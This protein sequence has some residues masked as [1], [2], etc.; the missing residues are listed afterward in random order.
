M[1]FNWILIKLTLTGL[2][3][4]NKVRKSCALHKGW[5]TLLEAAVLA[6]LP[7]R[8]CQASWALAGGAFAFVNPAARTSICKA[9]FA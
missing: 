3:W 9:Y 1:V 5:E 8:R 4:V 2:P 7:C 6:R